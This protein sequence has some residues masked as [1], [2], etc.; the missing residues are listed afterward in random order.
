[1]M[2][3]ARIKEKGNIH[4]HASHNAFIHGNAGLSSKSCANKEMIFV[5]LKLESQLLHMHYGYIMAFAAAGGNKI[6]ILYYLHQT[7]PQHAKLLMEGKK[8]CT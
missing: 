8:L 5:T 1:S 6:M 4:F 7:H 2:L 3:Y